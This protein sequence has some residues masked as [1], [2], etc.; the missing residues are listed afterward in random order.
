VDIAT[1]YGPKVYDWIKKG[2]HTGKKMHK[3]AKEIFAPQHNPVP[4]NAI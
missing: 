4:A 2:I 3:V 1:K